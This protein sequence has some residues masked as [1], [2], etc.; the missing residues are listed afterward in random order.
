MTQLTQ[1]NILSRRQ[2]LSFGGGLRADT[3]A[4]RNAGNWLTVSRAAMACMFRITLASD[5]ERG[6]LGAQDSLD[7]VDRLESILSVFSPSSEASRVNR[8][9]AT[10]PVVVGVELFELL[11]LCERLHCET[12]GAFDITTGALSECWGFRD[13]KPCLP[14]SDALVDA[15]EHAG[16]E[17]IL[18]SADNTVSLKSQRARVNFGGIGK[19]YALDKG[20]LKLSALELTP[21]L[22]SAGCSSVL[23]LGQGPDGAGW[24]VDIRH[25]VFKNR[26]LCAVRLRSGAMGTSGQEEQSFEANGQRYG[27]ILDPRT[28]VPAKD[29]A[30][31]SVIADSA[32]RADA[33]ATAFFVGGPEL[34][35]RYCSR[36]EGVIAIMLPADDLSHALVIG[37]NNHAT[38]ETV[39]E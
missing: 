8:E 19:G 9:S 32:A 36:H 23:A 31:V 6:V 11:T 21:A 3:A 28:G 10:H 27:H 4:S 7:E 25:P 26:R 39:N 30:S 34:A 16:F 29:M 22:L 17:H 24:L 12:E 33:L 14:T 2:L 38:V 1:A 5:G 37:S 20:A 15:K 18:L 13:R 35:K